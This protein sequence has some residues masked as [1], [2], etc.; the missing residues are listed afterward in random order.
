MIDELE[1]RRLA[2]IERYNN[3]NNQ[4]RLNNCWLKILDGKPGAKVHQRFV[5][6]SSKMWWLW[7]WPKADNIEEEDGGRRKIWQKA[8]VCNGQLYDVYLFYILYNIILRCNIPQ[9][10]FESHDLSVKKRTIYPY[11]NDG[12]NRSARNSQ[13][14]SWSW[15][16]SI[17]ADRGRDFLERI[18]WSSPNILIFTG[19]YI[20]TI[21]LM[22]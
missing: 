20:L 8:V 5:R 1:E 22:K 3:T 10:L 9:L 13:F 6:K 17:G 15:P 2:K 21:V 12:R 16:P 14:C 7:Y 4:L 18:L 19:I 11:G